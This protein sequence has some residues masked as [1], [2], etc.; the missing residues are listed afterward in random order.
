MIDFITWRCSCY[1]FLSVGFPSFRS[2]IF[3]GFLGGS[4]C[5]SH[6]IV[7][8]CPDTV[9][10]ILVVLFCVLESRLAEL[11]T[12]TCHIDCCHVVWVDPFTESSVVAG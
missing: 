1:T 12:L 2:W 6:S 8:V 3:H 10:A 4:S 7:S 5:A 9:S 11:C